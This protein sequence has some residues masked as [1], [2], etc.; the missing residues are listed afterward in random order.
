MLRGPKILVDYNF[1]L[2][3]SVENH[4]VTIFIYN[5]HEY[6]AQKMLTFCLAHLTVQSKSN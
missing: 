6:L 4:V 2:S 1:G 5:E 3:T